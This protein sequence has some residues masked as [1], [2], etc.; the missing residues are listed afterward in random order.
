[1]KG[2]LLIHGLHTAEFLC[3]VVVPVAVATVVIRSVCD[4]R[5]DKKRR[6]EYLTRFGRQGETE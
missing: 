1:M 4:S 3:L 6:Q 5:A 2:Y